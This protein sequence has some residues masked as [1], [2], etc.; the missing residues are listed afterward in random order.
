MNTRQAILVDNKIEWSQAGTKGLF[1]GTV[2]Y[3]WKQAVIWY[4]EE[5]MN[6]DI[7]KR[8]DAQKDIISLLES[9]FSWISGTH[10]EN[11]NVQ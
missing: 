5:T 11:H 7:F 4:H 6:L 10:Q 3:T 2:H 8:K 1:N 9:Q